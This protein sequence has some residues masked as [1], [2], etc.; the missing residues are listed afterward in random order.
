DDLMVIDE[1]DPGHQPPPSTPALESWHR[2]GLDTGVYRATHRLARDR[3]ARERSG[4]AGARAG[5]AAALAAVVPAVMRPWSVT[6]PGS[7]VARGTK[8]PTTSRRGAEDWQQPDVNVKDRGT[9]C[10]RSS[11]TSPCSATP[12]RSPKQSPTACPPVRRSPSFTSRTLLPTCR[13]MWTWSS[14]VGRRTPSP[15][16]G[17]PPG[18][19]PPAE[20]ATAL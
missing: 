9:P 11:S 15:C 20:E 13:P 6:C 4:S 19:K 16:P 8:D 2:C 14:S 7:P 10:A 5:A 17:R 18:R 3:W 12:P 1:E